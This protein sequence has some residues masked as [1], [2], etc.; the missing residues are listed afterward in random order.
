MHSVFFFNKC[1][2]S[3]ILS[4]AIKNSPQVQEGFLVILASHKTVIFYSVASVTRSFTSAGQSLRR[5]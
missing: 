2:A 1:E 4:L 5:L 3:Q